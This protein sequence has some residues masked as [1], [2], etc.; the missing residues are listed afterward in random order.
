MLFRS[1]FFLHMVL[2]ASFVSIPLL[3]ANDLAIPA[4]RHYEVYIPVLALSLLCIGP[5][6]R[7]SSKERWT[8]RLFA[9]AIG[10]LALA[11]CLLCVLPPRVFA[12]G[13]ALTLFFV[14]FNFLEASLPSLISRAAPATRKGAALGTYSTGQFLGT[15]IGGVTGGT[16]THLL[17]VRGVFG[18][19]AVLSVCWFALNWWHHTASPVAAC[20]SRT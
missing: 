17:G 12:V 19:A 14:G 3:L 10:C 4:K 7:L 18:A 16:A 15:F 6:L 8:G 20:D 2:A 13:G 11:E 1:V 5:M 9:F